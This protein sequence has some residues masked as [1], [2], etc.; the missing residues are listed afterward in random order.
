MQKK[1]YYDILGVAQKASGEDIKKAYRKLAIKYHPDKNPDNKEA[2]NKFKEATEAYEV[3]SDTA[4]RARYDQFGHAGMQGGSDYGQHANM[5]DIFEN[6]G[7]VFSDLFGGSPKGKRKGRSGPSPKQGH[8]LAK[9]MT[10]SLK[11]AFSGVKKDISVYHY[12]SCDS[13]RGSG[14]RS[15]TGAVQ[16]STCHGSGEMRYQQGFFMFAQPCSRCSG[17]GFIIESPCPTC[18]GQSR[19][20]KYETLSVSI[21]AG[22]YDGAELRLNG[23]G[24]AGVFGGPSGNLHLQ[25]SVTPEKNFIRHNNDLITHVMLTYPQLVLGCQI[26]VTSIDGSRETVKIARGTQVGKEIMI[27]SKGFPDI[28]GKGRGNFII[29][30]NCDIPTKLDSATKKALQEY[31]D[32]LGEKTTSEGGVSEFFKKFLG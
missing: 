8:D 13:C 31:A 28:R 24:D 5:N 11:E 3:L 27:P 26:E 14:S 16:C 23:K 12:I 2:E 9:A 21:P 1:D 4:K 15:G 18:K 25:I 20:Q 32:S 17:D 30:T 29:I 19:V 6:F 10:I 22:V 7:D